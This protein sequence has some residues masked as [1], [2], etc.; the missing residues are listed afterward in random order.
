M[1][2]NASKALTGLAIF[3]ALTVAPQCPAWDYEG[4]RLIARLALHTL[5]AQFPA[6]ARSPEA[7]ERV[8]FLSGEPDRWRNTPDAAFAHVNKPDHF[9]DI[10]ELEYYGITVATLSPFRYE[11]EAQF[12]AGR[13]ANPQRFPRVS[14]ARDPDFTRGRIGS[15]PWAITEHEGRLK[16]SFS[17][18]RAFEEAGTPEE[19]ANAHQNILY[20]MG[21]MA[22]FVGDAVQ[23]LHTTRH[24]NGWVGPNPKGYSTNRTFHGWIDGG[25]P[26]RLGLEFEALVPRLRPARR[27]DLAANGASS[28]NLFPAM[29]RLIQRGYEKVEPLYQLDRDGKL[30][31]RMPS[32]EGREFI[33]SQMVEGAQMLGDLWITAWQDAPQDFFLKAQLARRRLDR[34]GRP[35][36]STNGVKPPE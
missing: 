31:S 36:L 1:I 34:S 17:Y 2:V 18:L 21:V 23:P 11:A 10:D 33:V 20:T 29:I 3:S 16:S 30:S 5:P 28:T 35:G 14:P 4:H 8:A 9:F 19:T 27:L 24:F 13:A 7:M 6:F 32:A 25:F 15:L 12:A 22:H 26:A